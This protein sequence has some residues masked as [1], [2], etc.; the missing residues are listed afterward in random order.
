LFVDE[1]SAGV[2]DLTTFAGGLY[3]NFSNAAVGAGGGL[4]AGENRTW[5]DNFQ[6]GAPVPE[7]YG[8]VLLLAPAALLRR[9]RR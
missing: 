6:V 3:Q 9:R 4:G 5:T 1:Q 7:P 2:I 8:L